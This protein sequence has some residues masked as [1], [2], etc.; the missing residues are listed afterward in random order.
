MTFKFSL[1]KMQKSSFITKPEATFYPLDE[2][3]PEQLR[4]KGFRWDVKR[5]PK[6]MK[7]NQIKF[8]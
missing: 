8:P 3:K 1:G 2:L 5:K 4:L 7:I 6:T